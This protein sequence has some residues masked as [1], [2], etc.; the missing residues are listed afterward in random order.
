MFELSGFVVEHQTLDHMLRLESCKSRGCAIQQEFMASCCIID[1]MYILESLRKF[2][3]NIQRL[4]FS[5]VKIEN[6]TRKNLIF[7][8]FLLKT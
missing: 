6:F 1:Y 4:F 2:P 3:C 5:A 7:L 8:I